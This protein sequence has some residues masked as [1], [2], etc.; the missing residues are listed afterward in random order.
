MG[1]KK[2]SKLFAKKTKAPKAPKAPKTAKE[3]KAKKAPDRSLGIKAK[4]NC[5]SIGVIVLFTVIVVVVISRFSS[6]NKQYQLVLENISKITYIDTNSLQMG[7]TLPNLC[8]F[9]STVEET[10]Y[11]EMVDNMEQYAIDIR[12]NIPEDAIYTQNVRMADT[13][14]GD[15]GK[16][17]ESYRELVNVC[18]GTDFTTA[19]NDLA[20]SI[21]SSTA[22]MSNNCKLLLNVEISRSEDLEEQIEAEMAK[23]MAFVIALVV[24]A[25]VGSVIASLYI[26]RSLTKPLVEVNNRVTVIAGGDLTGEDIAVKQMDEVGQ[27]SVSF[28]KMKYS[29]T[30]IIKK[31]L[32]SSAGLQEAMNSVT[33]SMEE[34]TLGCTRI[35]ESVMEM[36]E[37]LEEQSLEVKK[38]VEQIQEMELISENVVANAGLI[39]ENSQTTMNN[40]EKGVVQL[41]SYVTQMNAINDSIDEVNKIFASFSENTVKMTASLQAISDIAAQT[42]LLSLNASIEA[43]RA[44]E[45]GRGFA[46][47]ADEI[48][49]LA[50]DSQAA[51]SEIGTMID[52]IK[53]ESET[54]SKKLSD[55]VVQLKQGNELTQETKNNFA[56]IKEGTDEVSRSVD[57]IIT[58]L[59]TLNDKINETS[60]SAD[61]IQVA[62]NTSVTDIDEINAIVAEESANIASVSQTTV[63]LSTLTEALEKEANSFR[64]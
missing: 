11:N 19:G 51:A 21:G 28:N 25:V 22:F 23:L 16:F 17:V 39:G 8:M 63:D 32:E 41:E 13:V 52:T 29:V 6:I 42:N 55:S 43:A 49:K 60:N 44:G 31:I 18:G 53:N 62:A 54:M 15:V 12:K 45:A 26:S 10:G 36:Q 35:A 57:D 3:P 64:V 46:V 59:K 33:V 50:D 61:I 38:I 40:A 24:I 58:K 56:V 48:R 4:I 7:K 14:A 5:M 30:G 27:L 37:K 2:D 47:V 9:G 20:Q 1:E 34:N